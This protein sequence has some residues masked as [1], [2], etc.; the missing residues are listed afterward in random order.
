MKGTMKTINYVVIYSGVNI[1]T[2]AQADVMVWINN[3]SN[4]ALLRAQTRGKE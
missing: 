2:Q 3:Q 1:N 4:T